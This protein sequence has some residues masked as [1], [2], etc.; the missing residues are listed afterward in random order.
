VALIPCPKCRSKLQISNPTTAKVRC[1]NCEAIFSPV[2]TE[3]P[4]A[5]SSSVEV[6]EG[7]P[8]RSSN[9]TPVP[10]SK[11]PSSE[12]PDIEIIDAEHDRG[13][14][15]EE[16]DSPRK[17]SRPRDL[18]DESTPRRKRRP[19]DDE[20][21]EPNIRKKRRVSVDDDADD[22][23]RRARV[24]REKRSNALLIVIGIIV[25]GLV[26]LAV[27]GF[28]AL[29]YAG[30]N[31]LFG[32][33]WPDP[34]GL[35][36]I[37][38]T[39]ETVTLHITPVEDQVTA[40]AIGYR[41]GE[42]APSGG[43]A[44]S[45]KAP[46][47][48]FLINPGSSAEEFSKRI[49]FGRVVSV[50]GSIISVLADK[51]EAPQLDSIELAIR[52]LKS[53]NYG[54]RVAALGK[55]S[56][57]PPD[58]HQAD[59]LAALEPLLNETDVPI[60]SG[61]EEAFCAWATKEKL[62]TLL[63]FVAGPPFRDRWAMHALARLKDER[64]IGPIIS[65]LEDFHARGE[66]KAALIVYGAMAENHVLKLLNHNEPDVRSAACEILAKIGSPRSYEPIAALLTN[67]RNRGPA[68]NALIGFGP[69]AEDEVLKFV[70]HSDRDT[71]SRACEILVKIGTKKSLPALE[72]ATMDSDL[73]VRTYS[74]EAIAEIKKRP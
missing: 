13:T 69:P 21:Y 19:K 22:K 51:V 16:S 68:A 43:S 44:S 32:G 47:M 4:K 34:S 27:V 72:K 30:E 54:R 18:E 26:V 8:K 9:P 41:L 42:L 2:A 10:P 74:T 45:W 71:R 60:R 20:D 29:R 38:P 28:F 50:K 39:G 6:L 67:D 64:G 17:K 14:E 1:P 15:E 56:H 11:K 7:T 52:D 23:P 73:L 61:A 53:Q 65:R 70:T 58:K 62:A 55:L 46:R 12:E 49:D 3:V 5:P 36:A 31:L 59:V 25:G 57:T 24:K 33:E 48:T 66:A 40:D 35:R 37:I 63:K